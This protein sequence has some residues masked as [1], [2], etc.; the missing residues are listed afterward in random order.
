MRV[1]ELAK[2]LGVS[3]KE[4]LAS[5]ADMGVAGKSAS[6]SVPE[7]MVPRLRASG[8]KATTAPAKPREVLEP[9]PQPR[10]VAP[11]PPPTPKSQTQSQSQSPPPTP[12]CPRRP[13]RLRP[14][15]SPRP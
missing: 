8:G 4:L 11:P 9:P 5:L 10:G 1:H 2:E 6:S 13:P 7:D 3:S 14:R 12:P 15:R